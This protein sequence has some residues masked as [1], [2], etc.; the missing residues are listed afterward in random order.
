MSEPAGLTS[1]LDM[2]CEGKWMTQLNCSLVVC[3]A[4]VRH[5]EEQALV[6]WGWEMGTFRPANDVYDASEYDASE[7]EISESPAYGWHW[8]LWDLMRPPKKCGYRGVPKLSSWK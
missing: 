1:G 2:E 6:G 3:R 7:Y 8:T 5:G 4:Q